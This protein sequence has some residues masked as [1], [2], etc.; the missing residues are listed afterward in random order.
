MMFKLPAKIPAKIGVAGTPKVKIY[1]VDF[2]W[3]KPTKYETISIDCNGSISV[4]AS[5]D[6]S[7]DLEIGLSLPAKQMDAFIDIFNKGLEN[8]FS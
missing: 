1:D 2:G 7:E 8:S 5:S 4:N 3:G 6:S